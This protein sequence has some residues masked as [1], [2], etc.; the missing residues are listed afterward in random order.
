MIDLNNT[1]FKNDNPDILDYL[2][3][4]EY[5]PYS[6]DT[7]NGE[8]LVLKD[9]MVLMGGNNVKSVYK[10]IHLVDGEFQYVKEESMGGEIARLSENLNKLK[11]ELWN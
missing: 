3:Q 11:E 7:E 5:T 9:K 8:W 10:Q 2:F 1:C 4:H 6:E